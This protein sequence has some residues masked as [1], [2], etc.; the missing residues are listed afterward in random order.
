MEISVWTKVKHS[1]PARQLWRTLFIY[2]YIYIYIVALGSAEECSGSGG[3]GCVS[4]SQ[5][6]FTDRKRYH[7]FS[8]GDVVCC[9]VCVC[10]P[11]R[12]C[13]RRWSEVHQ[14]LFQLSQQPGLHFSPVRP[15]FRVCRPTVSSRQS[16]GKKFHFFFIENC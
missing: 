8:S 5:L 6:L 12:S 7:I 4:I 9:G 1:P 11:L 10:S 2:I 13:C 16:T 14:C 3:F 15:R